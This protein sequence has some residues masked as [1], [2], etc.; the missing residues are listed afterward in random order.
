MSRAALSG[1]VVGVRRAALAAACTVL[2]LPLPALSAG[3]GPVP[4]PVQPWLQERLAQAEPAQPLRVY[5]HADTADRA[6]AA[7][8]SAGLVVVETF[9]QVAVVVADGPAGAVRRAA[10]QPHVSYVEGDLPVELSLDKAHRAT[11]NAEAQASRPAGRELSGAGVS[12]AVI[13]TGVDG[14]HPFFRLPDGRSKVVANHKNVCHDLGY[15]LLRPPPNPTDAC[16]APVLTN[17]SDTG[18]A[19]GHG[20]HVAG[21]VAGVP[22]AV[23]SPVVRREQAVAGAAPGASVVAL[24]VGAGA[25]IYGG[26][27]GLNWVLNHHAQ[28]CGP[29]VDARACPPIRVTNSSYGP[30]GGSSF[31]PDGVTAKL[32]RA[33]VAAGVV[34]VWAAGNDGGDGSGKDAAGR[35]QRTNGPGADPTPGVLLVASYDHGVDGTR[36]GQPSRF[37]SRGT[38]GSPATY[39]DLAAPGSYVLSSCR[40]TMP[41]CAGFPYDGPRPTDVGTFVHLSGTSMAAPYVAGVVAELLQ[42]DPTL[43]PGQVEIALEDGAHRFSAGAP[44]EHDPANPGSPTSFDKGHGLVDVVGAVARVQA[45]GI[46]VPMPAPRPEPQPYRL[47]RG[48]RSCSTAATDDAGDARDGVTRQ[49][50]RSMDLLAARWSWDGEALTAAF[51]VP[52]LGAARGPGGTGEQFSW[53]VSPGGGQPFEVFTTA[54][55]TSLTELRRGSA[56]APASRSLVDRPAGPDEVRVRFT[57]ADLARLPGA[58]TAL[59]PGLRLTTERVD[60]FQLNTFVRTGADSASPNDCSYVVGAADRLS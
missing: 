31:D 33:L 27:T 43:T 39:P 22:T 21:I 7:A 54:G 56:S 52:D 14:T 55:L 34:V 45:G 48:E 57:P 41:L 13:D 28:P 50:R 44:Y 10:L 42:L 17:D 15:L 25:S 8:E 38:A 36:D 6:R 60:S 29:D 1:G 24:S 47:P 51:V 20:T 35:A 37:S 59:K 5:V 3:S 16:W 30:A 19:A 32:Q 58:A 26:N 49:E 2:L 40:V 12:V 23:L 11:R 18:S 4:A 9:E 46:V 53:I